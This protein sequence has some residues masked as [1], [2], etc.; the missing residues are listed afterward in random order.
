MNNTKRNF[1]VVR[2]E[3]LS[4]MK[5][6]RMRLVFMTGFIMLILTIAIIISGSLQMEAQISGSTQENMVETANKLARIVEEKVK[7][8]TK[9]LSSFGRRTEFNDFP[10]QKDWINRIIK[11]ETEQTDYVDFDIFDPKGIALSDGRNVSERE[12]FKL[13]MQG[14]SLFSDLIINMQNGNKIFVVS[15]PIMN[16]GKINGVVAGVKKADFISDLAKNY[17]YGESGYAFI[18]NDKGFIL[19]H[20]DQTLVESNQS[21]LELAKEDSAFVPF[22][23]EFQNKMGELQADSPIG[24]TLEYEWQGK[25]WGAFS[26]IEG[27]NWAVVVQVKKNEI[28][29]PIK[30]TLLSLILVSILIWIIALAVVYWVSKSISDPILNIA[31]LVERFSVFNFV[32]EENRPTKKYLNREDE[33]GVITRAMNKM[34]TNLKEMVASINRNAEQLSSS[35][36]ELTAIA[37]QTTNSSEEVAK[38]IEEIAR[39]A[40]AQA[41]DTQRGALSVERLSELLQNNS[42]LLLVLNEA[43]DTVNHLKNSGIQTLKVLNRTTEDNKVAA[44]QVFEVIEDTNR[45]TKKIETASDMISSIADQTNLLALNAAIEAAR[46]GEAG[47]GFSVVADEIRKLAED[48]TRF[49]KEIKEIIA[50]LSK[51]ADFAVVTIS[52][53]RQIVEQQES[54]VDETNQ[55]FEGIAKAIEKSKEVIAKINDVEHDIEEQKR[56]VMDMIENLSS[57]SEENAASTEE[58]S[59]SMEEQVASIEQVSVASGQLAVVAEDLT[60]FTQQFKLN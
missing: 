53:V 23:E 45:S 26:K 56:N 8:E 36:Q 10:L 5:S 24:G 46:A 11:Q 14:Q 31:R 51:K 60:S 50:E 39:G 34:I 44:Q 19:G 38:T 17:S 43:T 42:D 18:I 47:K 59:A 41:E 28:M 12:Y 35:S 9:Y 3:N 21:V 57:I 1:D 7:S 16:N 20:R 54:S 22:V 37:N 4:K 29:A 49:T 58:A 40:S 55:Q 33:I 15:A 6:I 32:L 52:N 2:G 13:G 27:T 25:R 48:S 30:T